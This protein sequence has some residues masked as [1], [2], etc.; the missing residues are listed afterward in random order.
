MEGTHNNVLGDRNGEE[1]FQVSRRVQ[2]EASR[3]R[4]R[5]TNAAQLH[6]E[7]WL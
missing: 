1:N 2:V 5:E 7:V 6:R 3:S 4:T